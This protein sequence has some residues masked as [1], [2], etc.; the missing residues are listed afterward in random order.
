[1]KSFIAS[2]AVL[3][4]TL[5]FGQLSA[6]KLEELQ[7]PATP[8]VQIIGDTEI[9]AHNQSKT[10]AIGEP[11]P[12][13]K[14]KAIKGG[15]QIQGNTNIKARQEGSLVMKGLAMRRGQEVQAEEPKKS[16]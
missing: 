2:I 16:E 12:G 7:R 3:I 11:N 10:V 13:D 8:P 6:A 4:P 1:V 15:T 9:K 14:Q 5:A